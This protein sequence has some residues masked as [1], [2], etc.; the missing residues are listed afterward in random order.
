MCGRPVVYKTS[1]GRYPCLLEWIDGFNK[2][3]SPVKWK[4]PLFNIKV[5]F[6]YVYHI[7]MYTI[8]VF[9]QLFSFV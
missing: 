3:K 7:M 1:T 8:V 4:S 6:T 2:K 9:S 5:N